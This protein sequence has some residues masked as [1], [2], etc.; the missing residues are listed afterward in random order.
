[1]SL[2]CYDTHCLNDVVTVGEKYF[3][4][5][6]KLPKHLNEVKKQWFGYCTNKFVELNAKPFISTKTQPVT[7]ILLKTMME[8]NSKFPVDGIIFNS[9]SP[10]KY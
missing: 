8:S 6:W 2:F 3:F 5:I 9:N 1:M 10:Y 7:Q 4:R